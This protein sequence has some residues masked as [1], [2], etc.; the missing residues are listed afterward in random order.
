MP[1]IDIGTIV[2]SS[3]L[4]DN[5]RPSSIGFDVINAFSFADNGVMPISAD[6]R[7]DMTPSFDSLIP[8]GT[9]G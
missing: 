9:V 2:F 4:V 6:R 7:R 3:R 5:Y 8:I 1:S